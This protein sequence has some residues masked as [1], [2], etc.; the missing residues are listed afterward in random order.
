[1]VAGTTYFIV[2]DAYD[3][4]EDGDDLATTLSISIAE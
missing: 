4:A 2:V 1:M 3:P